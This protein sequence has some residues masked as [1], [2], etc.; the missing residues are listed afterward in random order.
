MTD[1]RPQITQ[2]TETTKD[3]VNQ[4]G[5]ILLQANDQARDGTLGAKQ[6][7][8]SAHQLLNVALTAGLEL[9]PMAMPFPC[10]PQICDD[11]DLSDYITA[12]PD[13]ECE[14]TL[15]VAKSFTHV[16][17]RSC[18]I[19]DHLIVFAP[20]IL[21]VYAKRFRIGANLPDLRCGTY[22]GRVRLTQIQTGAK[23]V[24]EMDVIVDL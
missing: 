18:V 14:R 2:L 1:P 5:S 17:A 10:L 21:P 22:K 19:P 23:R 13:N 7:A 6:W 16:G 15:S 9:N 3:L 24:D 4:A 20:P 11:P 8:K 12:K